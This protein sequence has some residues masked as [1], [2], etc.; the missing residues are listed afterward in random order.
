MWVDNCYGGGQRSSSC[1]GGWAI[2][3]V[4]EGSYERSSD[5][6]QCPIKGDICIGACVILFIVWR[7]DHC[8]GWVVLDGYDIKGNDI[9]VWDCI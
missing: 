1:F 6:K 2:D 7:L 9:Q 3:V 8:K 5:Q 4:S